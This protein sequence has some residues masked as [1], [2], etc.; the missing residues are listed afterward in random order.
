ML[1]GKSTGKNQKIGTMK[2]R[3][4]DNGA[5]CDI[6]TAPSRKK[7]QDEPAFISG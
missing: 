7:G 1:A 2:G 4:S 5:L 6:L 3:M